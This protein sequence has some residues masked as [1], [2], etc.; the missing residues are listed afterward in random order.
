MRFLVVPGHNPGPYTGQGTNTYLIL[1]A[2]PTLIDAATGAPEH[3]DAVAAALDEAGGVEGSPLAQ[4]LATHAH[5]DHISGAAALAG[6]WPGARFAKRPWP[7]HDERSGITWQAVR[8]NELVPAGDVSLWAVHT[9]GHSPDHLCFFEPRSGLLFAGDLVINDGTVVIPASHGGSLVAYLDSL[10]RVLEL[11]PRRILPGHGR[12]IDQ[13]AAL[14]RSYLAHRL[15]RERQILDCLAD[16]PLTVSAIVERV[17]GGLSQELSG[18]AGENVLAH[19]VK[20]RDEG[21]AVDRGG[22]WHTD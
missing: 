6:R 13:P 18:A 7:G 14:I 16:G 2:V 10:R 9:P 19:L 17:Y 15:A 22:A 4:V 8:E 21:R 20:L 12:A 5:V 11:Q 3:I 1:G